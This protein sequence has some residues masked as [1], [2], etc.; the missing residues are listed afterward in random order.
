GGAKTLARSLKLLRDGFPD[1]VIAFR[2]E[3]V[4]GAGL[5][6]QRYNGSLNDEEAVARLRSLRGGANSVLTRAA[7][8]KAATHETLPQCTA[9]ALVE[10]LN[11]GRGGKKLPSWWA[12]S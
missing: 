8:V 4:E 10:I 5:I 3:M 11:Q 9:A 1:D 12:E 2:R 7:K 6:C